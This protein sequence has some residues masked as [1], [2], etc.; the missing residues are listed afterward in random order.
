M[1]KNKNSM[2]QIPPSPYK[3]PMEAFQDDK[4]LNNICIDK[5]E[6]IILASFLLPYRVER[7]KKT[8]GLTIQKC[9]HNPTMLYGTLENMIFKKQY[10]FKWIGLVTTLEDVSE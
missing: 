9:F 1:P 10:N 2:L 4:Q 5:T 7:E 6:P 8:G 3:V